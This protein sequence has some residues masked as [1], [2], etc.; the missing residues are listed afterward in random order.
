[1]SLNEEQR[2]CAKAALDIPQI[3]LA[4]AGTGKTTLL[5]ARIAHMLELGVPAHTILAMTFTNKAAAEMRERVEKL[6]GTA[7]D[8]LTLTTFHSLCFRLVLQYH[9]LLG[10]T[11]RPTVYSST[12][13]QVAVVTEA[14]ADYVDE[15]T[16]HS[17]CRFLD[18]RPEAAEWEDIIL[19][20][21]E[22]FAPKLLTS[23]GKTPLGQS[24]L[25][26][27]RSSDSGRSEAKRNRNGK[28][29]KDRSET[30]ELHRRIRDYLVQDM[31]GQG[32]SSK[33]HRQEEPQGRA[34][35]FDALCAKQQVGAQEGEPQ[36]SGASSGE[37][38]D[39][40]AEED[41][42]LKPKKMLKFIQTAKNGGFEAEQYEV[43]YSFVFRRYKDRMKNA[44][45]V[46][47]DDMMSL[48]VKLFDDHPQV[49]AKTR[50]R[51]QHLLV[52]EFQDTST[53]QLGL[54]SAI[55][56]ERSSILV[57]GDDDQTIYSFRGANAANFHTLQ[58]S[59][60]Q[61]GHSPM[62]TAL[63][64]NYRSTG[65][66]LHLSGK[67][68]ARNQGRC[69]TKLLRTA[70]PDGE[71]VRMFEFTDLRSQAE[72][73]AEEIK[74]YM[75]EEGDGDRNL[76]DVAVLMRSMRS[77]PLQLSMPL[78]RAFLQHGIQFNL[79]GATSIFDREEVADLMC[80][81]RLLINEDDDAAF[82]RVLN[83]P[84]RG[85]GD[86]GLQSI[87]D[88]RDAMVYSGRRRT[89]EEPSS[90]LAAAQDLLQNGNVNLRRPNEKHLQSLSRFLELIRSMRCS[91]Q[92]LG[93]DETLQMVIQRVAYLPYLKQRK[94]SK[95][96]SR[97]KAGGAAE[98]EDEEDEDEGATRG[99]K[100]EGKEQESDT[101]YVDI[102][103]A[104]AQQFSQN[105]VLEASWRE[106]G[107]LVGEEGE[108]GRVVP[109]LKQL[110]GA[111][112]MSSFSTNELWSQA[113]ALPGAAPLVEELHLERGWGAQPL[114]DFLASLALVQQDDKTKGGEEEVGGAVTICTVHKAK[115]LEWDTVFV[116]NLN[117]DHFPSVF[118]E[119]DSPVPASHRT[120]EAR[121]LEAHVEEERRL[122]H[123][124]MTRARRKLFLTANRDLLA[125]PQGG[126]Q[127][128][129]EHGP[130]G[131]PGP[132]T[133][134]CSLLQPF[135][136]DKARVETY[137][138]EKKKRQKASGF[139]S[140]GAKKGTGTQKQPLAAR[141]QGQGDF[142]DL[143][144]LP[145]LG[146]GGGG[147]TSALSLM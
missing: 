107:G 104:E 145:G 95:K 86:E 18:L 17:C 87:I 119:N 33:K 124:A 98:S 62:T 79:I 3:V 21:V 114:A 55:R 34:A 23:S 112:L 78:Q 134:F 139:F 77:G 113:I 136:R 14:I 127:E 10:F 56:G 115:G 117:E 137:R 41:E 106:E 70:G 141:A 142:G 26:Q 144:G 48:T 7:A 44:N 66:I 99:K 50:D 8:G 147:F 129:E 38:E 69:A 9:K 53:L 118:R 11:Q 25:M 30:A 81:M 52:D 97:K 51:Y 39:E 135:L 28:T 91:M 84:R 140:F 90:L 102:L 36:E 15:R 27:L 131:E 29:P 125:G 116:L 133:C 128:G 57:V 58:N 61:A 100:K 122:V 32:A 42:A 54:V 109:T 16:K 71:R 94:E 101:E 47:F 68:I 5:T 88:H 108:Q 74:R 45:A 123:V 4:G 22:K 96:A 1:M 93:P 85:I 132:R 31:L 49:L 111:S 35:L 75:G 59:L 146:G 37:E 110:A 130:N 103:I 82:K 2:I 65:N 126:F 20:F 72:R 143:P 19:A 83:T 24:L 46:D 121:L 12:R 76:D 67:V 60:Q 92:R 138:Q 63:E 73:V 13:E 40:D 80:Y 64:E 43:P 6:V 105:W 89:S 120:T